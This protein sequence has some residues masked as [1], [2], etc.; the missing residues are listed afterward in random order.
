MKSTFSHDVMNSFFLWFDNFL[1][2]KVDAYKTYTT[3]FYNYT[4]E[5]LGGSKVVYGSPYKQFAYDNSITGVTV[6]SGVTVDGTF[7]A[8]GT[9]GMQFDFDN[10]RVI[11]NS[12]VNTGLDI[13][14]TYTVKEINSYITDQT[15][16]KLIIENKYI[17]NSR[18]TVSEDYIKPYTPVTPAVFAS[19]E[20]SSNKPFS[21]GGEDETTSQVKI[22]AFCENLYQLDGILSTFTDSF[23]EIIAKIPT[24]SHPIGEFGAVKSGVYP[25]GYDYENVK[26]ANASNILFISDVDT[27][28][29]RDN[30]IKELNP[31]LNIGFVDFEIKAFRYPRL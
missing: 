25:T 28:K 31:E 16:E 23:N 13:S 22:V 21:F 18:F 7:L 6:P 24:S 19:M 11:F 10:G 15:E 30:N 8:T 26:A 17:T 29:I 27:S 4:D 1:M 12:G 2:K 9:S 20:E 3:K 14:G 5:R